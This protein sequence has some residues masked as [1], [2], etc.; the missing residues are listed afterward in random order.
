M[1]LLLGGLTQPGA[2][3]APWPFILAGAVVL[4]LT[5]HGAPAD[6]CPIA[7]PAGA[8]IT[9][10]GKE[11][12]GKRL[13]TVTGEAKRGDKTLVVRAFACSAAALLRP[14]TSACH[15]AACCCLPASTHP[16]PHPHPH[17]PPALPALLPA[18]QVDKTSG[19][20]VGDIYIVK[21][22]D[23]DCVFTRSL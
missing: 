18:C 1:L 2:A 23:K 22:R 9:V 21:Y 11:G 19:L 6:A 20:K 7:P 3:T 5:L 13:A 14:L 4:G 10:V 16:P 15:H 17:P 12:W 8:F